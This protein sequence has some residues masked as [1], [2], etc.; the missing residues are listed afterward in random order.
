[1]L[2]LLQDGSLADRG[3]TFAVMRP[4]ARYPAGLAGSHSVTFQFPEGMKLP[5]GKPGHSKV[6]VGRR[7][8]R[9][10]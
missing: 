2:Q 4:F 6:L 7:I 1:M 8:C 3:L 9:R 5:E 10:Y